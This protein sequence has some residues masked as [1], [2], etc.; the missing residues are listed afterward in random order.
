MQS[1]SI[2]ELPG[3]PAAGAT[4]TVRYSGSATD[5]RLEVQDTGLG[6]SAEQL[7]RI[8]LTFENAIGVEVT[9]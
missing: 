7:S 3:M 9:S 2:S 5:V 1:I 6:F 4:V 8:R